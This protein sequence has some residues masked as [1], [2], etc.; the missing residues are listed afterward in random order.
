MVVYGDDDNAHT[1][2]VATCLP[3]TPRCSNAVLRVGRLHRK[4]GET[5]M[6]LRGS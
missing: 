3:L 2:S 6:A 1:L 4:G 5:T